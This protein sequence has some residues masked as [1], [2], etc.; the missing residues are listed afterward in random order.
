MRTLP[1]SSTDVGAAPDDPHSDG[2]DLVA[3]EYAAAAREACQACNHLKTALPLTR[4]DADKQNLQEELFL[5]ELLYRT[6]LSCENTILFLHARKRWEDKGL[7]K[8]QREMVE[9]AKLEKENALAAL[10]I[11][12]KA[13]WLDVKLRTDG[14][15]SSCMDMI[16][17][18]VDW[19]DRFLAE[20]RQI[21]DST[22]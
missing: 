8:Y 22:I 21:P 5:T 20:S 12:P 15:Y 19:I 16:K 18:K 17:V 11:Y 2:W 4:T 6:F 1:D 13:P 3:E 10:P 9:T 7:L 14:N